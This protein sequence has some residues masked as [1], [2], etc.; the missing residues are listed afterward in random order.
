MA[1]AELTGKAAT[2]AAVAAKRVPPR[3]GNGDVALRVGF[4]FVEDFRVLAESP[5]VNRR[6]GNTVAGTTAQSQNNTRICSRLRRSREV[7]TVGANKSEAIV[8]HL[9]AFAT[10][11]FGVLEIGEK[12]QK[13]SETPGLPV[14]KRR[15]QSMLVCHLK[16]FATGSIRLLRKNPGRLD[17]S[18]ESG[19]DAY[20]KE[21]RFP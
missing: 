5:E 16:G 15:K 20:R 17:T 12:P 18:G 7:S 2:L 3:F 10:G 1:A 4:Y 19:V 6:P 8:K 11:R 13:A 14:S 9:F 21:E